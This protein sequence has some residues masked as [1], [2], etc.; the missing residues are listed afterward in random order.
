MQIP[1]Q[2]LQAFVLLSHLTILGFFQPISARQNA[3]SKVSAVTVY[4]ISA[5]VWGKSAL[6]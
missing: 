4:D 1:R 6:L 2:D 5:G 3:C